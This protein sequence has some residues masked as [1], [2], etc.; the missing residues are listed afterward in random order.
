VFLVVE[1][2]G[3]HAIYLYKC[4]SVVGR[5]ERDIREGERQKKNKTQ[6]RRVV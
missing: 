6:T 1:E 2:R 3:I 4:V 5:L